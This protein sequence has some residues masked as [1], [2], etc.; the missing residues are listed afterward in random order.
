MSNNEQTQKSLSTHIIAKQQ[1]TLDLSKNIIAGTVSIAP[2][3][4]QLTIQQTFDKAL[5]K[6]VFK[7]EAGQIGFSVVN[8]LVTRFIDS[9]GFS[10][11]LN[12]TQ[13]ETLTV[14]ILENFQYETL[15]DIIIFLKMARTGKFGSTGRGVDSNLILG[16]WFPKYLD[17]KAEI[18]EQNYQVEKTEFISN[19]SAVDLYYKNIQ[20]KKEQKKIFDNMISDIDKMVLNMNRT[21][22]EETILDWSKKDEM[23]PYLDYLKRKRLIIK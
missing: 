9:F 7:G 22:L 13:I 15:E 8:V 23:K 18:R 17:K 1:K 4:M 20:K 2:V 19:N 10:T 11:K 3:E 5:I 14:D 16:D 6:S 12:P 21:M